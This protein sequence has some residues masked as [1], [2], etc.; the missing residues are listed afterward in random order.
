[1]KLETLEGI[2]DNEWDNTI[3]SW[4]GR[5][6]YHQADWLQFIADSRP[7]IRLVRH[8][9][10]QDGVTRGYFAGFIEKKGPFLM[11]GSPL[12]KWLTDFMGPVSDSDLDVELFIHA[13]EAWCLKEHIQFLQIG[14]PMLPVDVMRRAGY[15]VNDMSLYSIA[16]SNSEAVMWERL[17]GKCRNRIRKGQKSGLYVE[18]CHDETIVEEYYAQHTDVFALQG[19]PPKYPIRT[20]RALVHN[21][22]K[23]G[24]VLCLRIRHSGTTVATGIFPHD[25]Q[26]LYSFGIASWVCY[27][28]MCPNELLYWSAMQW[29][30]TRGMKSFC[31]GGKYREPPSGGLF[32]DK[33][34]SEIIPFR[35]YAKPLSPSIRMAYWAFQKARDNVLPFFSRSTNPSTGITVVITKRRE[36]VTT[37]CSRKITWLHRAWILV[38][39]G[40]RCNLAARIPALLSFMKCRPFSANLRLTHSCS[41]RCKTCTHWQI[42]GDKDRE[43]STDIWKGILRDLRN[44]NVLSVSFTGGDILERE[45]APELIGYA[46]S[47]GLQVR[48]TLNGFR[49]TENVARQLMETCPDALTLSMDNFSETF[50]K[51]R[52]VPYATEKVLNALDLLCKHNTGA[53]RLGLSVTIMRNSL[54]GVRQV[55]RFA[56]EH[57][58]NI[59]FNLIHFTHYFTDTKFSRE[60]IELSSEELI[61][62]EELVDWLIDVRRANPKLLPPIA[63]LRWIVSYFKDYRQPETPCLKTMLKP[64]IDPDG[65][66]RACCSMDSVGNI[67]RTPLHEIV[68][69]SAYIQAV[70][71]GLKKTCPGCSCHFSMNLGANVSTLFSFG[72]NKNRKSGP[73]RYRF[74]ALGASFVRG[75]QQ[76]LVAG[77]LLRETALEL[78]Y[79]LRSSVPVVQ[80]VA[81]NRP[82]IMFQAYSVHH[83]LF[84]ESIVHELHARGADVSFQSLD[85]PHFPHGETEALQRFARERLRISPT[86]ITLYPRISELPVDLLVCADIYAR[87]PRQ[88]YQTCIIFHG[89]MLQRRNFKKRFFRKTLYDF[90]KVLTNGEYDLRLIEKY[91]SSRQKGFEAEVAGC[92]FLDTLIAPTRPRA[93]YLRQLG[94]DP[95][96]PTVLLGPTWQGLAMAGI[97]GNS[98]LEHVLGVLRGVEVNILVKLHVCSFNPIMA[99]GI[100]WREKLKRLEPQ[101][102]LCVDQDIDDR[103]ALSHADILITD[104][105]SRAFS[106]MMLDKPVIQY[107]PFS[108]TIDQWEQPRQDMFKRVC[109]VAETAGDIP[110]LVLQVGKPS[111][112]Q[113]QANKIATDCI[114][115]FGNATGYVAG[116]MLKWA[117]EASLVRERG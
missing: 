58:L 117:Q 53:T 48:A 14:H 4:P 6:I 100:D 23:S 90:D 8:R 94:L 15:T 77:R 44:Y 19:L 110:G 42:E 78:S 38:R 24:M 26:R 79:R 65:N 51:T 13:L 40:L 20:V 17:S 55:I 67:I 116:R 92:P 103:L 9:L 97:R 108:G 3:A 99:G 93:T 89:P 80:P 49:I 43:L 86:R 105:S 88:A 85:H 75:F 37:S 29:G 71:H 63:H 54:G 91:C 68:R 56:V 98:Y 109:M 46:V 35:R 73:W 74:S 64:C 18:E 81:G 52:G 102:L 16:L 21:L 82:S 112:H 111:F 114:A 70:R 62:L 5:M 27:R 39:E 106:F 10:I 107:F 57:G 95:D 7:G 28:N 36:S 45:D 83:A 11:L 32:K 96:K 66:V 113:P 61:S 101:E 59:S 72:F 60:Q 22:Q 84:F 2:S 115:R 47:L 50:E 41:G 69:S 33:F 34:N 87:F 1:M 12:F 104:M 30:G 31:I 25:N 76:L